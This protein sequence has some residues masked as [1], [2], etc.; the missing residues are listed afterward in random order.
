M[1][2]IWLIA[3][4]RNPNTITITTI[5]SINQGKT[6]RQNLA[7][8]LIFGHRDDLSSFIH[9]QSPWPPWDHKH[10]AGRGIG[11]TISGLNR[12]EELIVAVEL[13]VQKGDT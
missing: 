3:Q 9:L 12:L 4:L 5:V 13:K 2:L 1:S 10:G 6:L 7:I 11:F 8:N